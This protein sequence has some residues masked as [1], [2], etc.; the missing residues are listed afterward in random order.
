MTL[1]RFRLISSILFPAIER[2]YLFAEKIDRY[3]KQCVAVN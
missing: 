3:R 1:V 2:M